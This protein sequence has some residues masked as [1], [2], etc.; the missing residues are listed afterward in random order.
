MTE[1]SSGG[2]IKIADTVAKIVG[3]IFSIAVAVISIVF[4]VQT[5][6]NEKF[7][8]KSEGVHLEQ[9]IKKLEDNMRLYEAQ[10]NEIIRLLG[11]IE[12]QQNVKQ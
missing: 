6:G 3:W 8:P 12:G 5:Q 11:R 9:Q 1:N 4:W 2:F 10:N 7:Y